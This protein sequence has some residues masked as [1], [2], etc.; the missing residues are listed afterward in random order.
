MAIKLAEA[1]VAIVPSMKGVG[2]AIVSAFDGASGKAGLSGGKAAGSGFAGGL[3][4]KMGAV[5]GAASAITSKAMDTIGSS[6]S[7]AVS[8]ADQMN[9]FPKVM[10]NLG[11]SSEDAAKSIKKISDSLDGLPTTS[12]AMTGMVQQLAPLTSNLDEATTISLAFNNAMLAGGA[13]TMEQENALAQYTQM[14]SA[15]TVDMAAWR[16][17]QA[18]MPGQLNQVAEAMM[19]AG[20]NANDLYASMKDGTYSFD[21]FNKAIVDLNQNGFAQYASFAQ[22]A[23]DA[24][25]GIGTAIENVRNRVAKAVQKVVEA[26]GVENIAGAIN[27]FSSQF[28]KI[29]DAAASMVTFTKDQFSLLWDRVKDLGAIDTL[30][31]AW[32]GLTAKLSNTDWGNL[33]PAGVWEQLRN[34]AASALADVMD[35]VS[36]LIDWLS[37]G[38]Q[39]VADFARSFA[40]TGVFDA[41]IDVFGVVLDVINSATDVFGS[42]ID[43]IGRMTGAAGG[44]QSFGQTVG[45]AFKTI[46]DLIKP[47]LQVLDD[48]LG[49]FSRN[50]G[51]IVAA[52]GTIGTAFAGVKGYQAL[53][54]GLQV[55]K[56]T[57]DTV[58]GAAKGVSNGIQLM[59]DLGGPVQMLKQMGGQLNIVKNAQTAW[60]AAT[61]A[62]TAVQGAFNAI[63][64]A[65][66][67][68]AIIT[69]I[70]AV[71]A[72]LVWFF[73]QTEVG[74]KAWAAFTSWL[75]DAWQKICEVGKAVWEGLSSFFSGLWEGISSVAQSVW[76]GISSFFTG[77][78]DGVSS[79]WNTVWNGV[80][81]VFEAVWGFIQAYVQNV[82]MP[83]G[84]FI[85]NCFIVVAAVFVTI[86]NGIKA[87]WETVWNAIVAFFTPV[88][89]GISDTITTVCTFISETWNTVWTAVSGFFQSIW[90]GIVAFFTP[91]IEG[92]SNT[93]TTVVNAVKATWDSVWGAISSF[94]QTVWNGIVAFFTPVINGIRSTITNAV[95]AIRS[96][97]TSV[98]NSIS[99][100]FSGIWNGM[101]N[102]VGSAVGFIGDKVRSI[103]DTVFGALRGAGEW[104][105]DTG[106][107]LIQGLINGIGDMF[108]W[109]RDKICS[110]GSNVLSWAK[111]VLGIGSPSRIFKQY[112]QWL[113][114]G[115]AIGIDDAASRVGKAMDEMT[116]MVIGKGLD[117]GVE[118]RLNGMGM[119]G[120][121]TGGW[122]P[123]E[124]PQG[125]DG[126]AAGSTTIYQTINNPVA[127]PWPLKSA[128]DSDHRFQDA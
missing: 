89:Q 91:I 80:K 103:K 102:A 24:T 7:S 87:V 94:F 27:G 49:W 124:P 121:N 20:H 54:N 109:V 44:A 67:I 58:T 4:A 12:S 69:A 23:K 66:P 31:A 106:R 71:V 73:T 17:I 117:F 85:K 39:W 21:D 77:I 112:G 128:D 111:G 97:W 56:G 5:I 107:N 105:R 60:S 26:F 115:L 29:G 16:S 36:Q 98:W 25:Q 11:Y 83:I 108:G 1:Y 100:F 113:D 116:G 64:A 81:T 125:D 18:A 119:P 53:N 95:N 34:T 47:V 84:E 70:A 37:N 63:I 40:D 75:G 14:L 104:L 118:A 59:M 48:V 90:N 52:L 82:I 93:I 33:L 30:K 43:A 6:I 38:I 35:R 45:D 57:M 76:G 92:I 74:R 123:Y 9:N 3:K 42:V 114:E 10:K 120:V 68:G 32:D 8:R 101:R 79:V 122:R 110:L 50:P 28:G 51:V 61:K 88:I 22:Q 2:N 72:A 78:W 55:L 99:S 19:G 15:G 126:K 41:W 65:N 96:T 86:W 13:S 127:Q 62:A 46:A